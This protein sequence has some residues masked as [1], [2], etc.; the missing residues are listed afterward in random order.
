MSK[1]WS[2]MNQVTSLTGTARLNVLKGGNENVTI[3]QDNYAAQYQLADIRSVGTG[4]NVLDQQGL[5]NNIRSLLE[6]A[7]I[8]VT[9]DVN[10]NLVISQDVI[11][12]GTGA[13]VI[14]DIA[15]AQYEYR[16]LTGTGGISV[17]ES[18]DDLIISGAAGSIPNLVIVQSVSDFPA[19]VAGVITLEQNNYSIQAQ[20]DIGTNLIKP[21]DGSEITGF[22]ADI[23]GLVT[24]NASGL[25]VH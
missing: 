12:T 11:Q 16:T 13:E 19:A 18:G 8:D 9:L 25:F 14:K 24:N 7:G 17:T 2:Q 6:G 10:E 20:V 3:S 22:N 21:I 23:S 1:K 4:N 15:A 5:I